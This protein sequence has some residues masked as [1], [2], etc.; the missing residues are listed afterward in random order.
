M[1]FYHNKKRAWSNQKMEKKK[2]K[3]IKRSCKDWSKKVSLAVMQSTQYTE[4]WS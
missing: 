1:Q 4:H 3:T 2:K